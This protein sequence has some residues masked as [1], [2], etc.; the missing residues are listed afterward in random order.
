M[1]KSFRI[2]PN[3]GSA[4]PA[5]WAISGAGDTASTLAVRPHIL[6]GT[7]PGTSASSPPT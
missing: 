6:A 1:I 4:L 2:D 3:P 7:F 5:S